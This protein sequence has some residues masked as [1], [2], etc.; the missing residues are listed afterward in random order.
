MRAFL[1]LLAMTVGTSAF[2]SS[3]RW[4]IKVLDYQ[5][6]EEKLFSPSDDALSIKVPGA[7]T[8]V[9]DALPATKADAKADLSETRAL[10]C[11]K[12][13]VA[14]GTI[15]TCVRPKGSTQKFFL[16]SVDWLSFG[17]DGQVLGGVTVTCAGI[18]ANSAH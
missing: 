7:F 10:T 16:E 4:S 12:K 6:K 15:A 17:K 14:S 2:G 13:G 1:V 9:L 11:T 8:C 3:F 5:T 18:F